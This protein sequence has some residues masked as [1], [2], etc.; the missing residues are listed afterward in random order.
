MQN[1]PPSHA[2]GEGRGSIVGKSEAEHH[3]D[4]FY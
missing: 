2:P 4:V 3:K 1:P